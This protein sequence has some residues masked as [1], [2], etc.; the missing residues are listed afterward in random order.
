MT[1]KSP[2]P[3]F[4]DDSNSQPSSNISQEDLRLSNRSNISQE[5]LRSSNLPSYMINKSMPTMK[6]SVAPIRMDFSVPPPPLLHRPFLQVIFN[7]NSVKTFSTVEF[8][9]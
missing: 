3:N 5:D 1:F 9:N 4:S 7:I 2:S 8:Q 6:T